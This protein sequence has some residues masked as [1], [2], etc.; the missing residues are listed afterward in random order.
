M[1]LFA[2]DHG[3][4]HKATPRVLRSLFDKMRGSIPLEESIDIGL[5][6]TFR[7]WSIRQVE[8]AIPL[9]LMHWL[10][11]IDI[12]ESLAIEDMRGVLQQQVEDRRDDPHVYREIFEGLLEMSEHELGRARQETRSSR[13]FNSL[14]AEAVGSAKAVFDPACGI[15]GT[16]LGLQL[17]KDARIVG[18]EINSNVA[19]IAQMRFLLHGYRNFEIRAMDSLREDTSE[20]WDLI[21]TQP[22]FG[23]RVEKGS[24]SPR[25]QA[26]AP[27]SKYVQGDR[28]WLK[29]AVDSLAQGGS[30]FVVL[31]PQAVSA[32][33][34]AVDL[35]RE[36]AQ[37]DYLD[38]VVALP[39]GLIPGTLAGSLLVVLSKNRPKPK[40]WSTLVVNG[41]D[42]SK[43]SDE[44][45]EHST[46]AL[47]KSWMSQGVIPS[48]EEWHA[49]VISTAEL[50][51]AGFLP[52]HHL[53][54]PPADEEVRPVGH[55]RF[56]TS[57]TLENFKSIA[58]QTDIS[59]RPLTLIYGKNSAGKSSL[60]QSLLLLKQ[61]LQ[62]D[63][64]RTSGEHVNLGSFVGLLHRHDQT[65]TMRIG[66]AFSSSSEIDSERA[67][68]N[69]AEVRRV[70][71]DFTDEIVRV[72]NGPTAV[73]MGLEDTHVMFSVSESDSGSFLLPLDELSRAV[74]LAFRNEAEFP[75][76]PSTTGGQSRRLL[77]SMNRMSLHAVPFV[78]RNL[79]P[80]SVDGGFLR[81]V[82]HR[83]PSAHSRPGLSSSVLR[84]TSNYLAAIGE[85]LVRLFGRVHYIGPLRQPPARFSQRQQSAGE[86]D[87]PFF[88]LDNASER[89]QV[90]KW[91]LRLGTNYLLDAVNPIRHENR[92]AVGDVASVILTDQRSGVQVTP[93]DVG[94]G[95]SQVLPIVTELSARSNSIVLI[96]QPEI[97]LHPA[98]QAE[99]ADLLIES[100]SATGRGN[101]IIA[102][103]HSETLVLRVQ[104]RIREGALSPKDVI[105]LYV[106]QSADGTGIVKELRLSEEGEFLDSWPG[107][108]FDEQF[109][110]LFG[111]F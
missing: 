79:L 100:S 40:F 80:G 86:V 10:D 72:G 108:F 70:Q 12:G 94:F 9:D 21:V 56:L 71:F 19:R 103:T 8:I 107:G 90:S 17:R 2:M 81:Q 35:L 110:E 46:G 59:L 69:P 105:V 102:E 98:M 106:D 18:Q 23:L 67:V 41:S 88:L 4:R 31:S 52:Q 14:V 93:A 43:T 20:V 6:E 1:E 82:D 83:D 92:D 109:T 38:A 68:P 48:V 75:G 78:R 44:A 84:R 36:F 25:L 64:I 95:I 60:I 29:L 63:R 55:G 62:S 97:H 15:G 101:Q 74:D 99:L 33:Q 30:A 42:L 49:R 26:T 13:A 5:R 28:L 76:R 37:E 104:N 32:R 61:S 22:P 96:E 89:E 91:L 3:N 58:E 51:D 87:M 65:K 47:L 7:L 27:E 53:P 73:S 45:V 11:S 66:V 111:E 39:P 57:L 77:S 85:E 50:V 54:L 24:L 16:L 34:G